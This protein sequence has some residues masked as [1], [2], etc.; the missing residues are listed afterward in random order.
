M[1]NKA[2]FKRGGVHPDDMK[3][4][5]KD[6]AVEVLPIPGEL[7]VSMSQHLGALYAPNFFLIMP[8]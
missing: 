7:Y 4:L 2:T 3:R 8:Q 5:S 6:K 1:L